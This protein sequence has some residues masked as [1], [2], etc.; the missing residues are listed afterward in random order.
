MGSTNPARL[1]MCVLRARLM[2]PLCLKVMDR[3]ERILVATDFSPGS[4]RAVKY[5]FALAE[6]FGAK[7]ELLHVWLPPQLV[8]QEFVLAD[9]AEPTTIGEY[10]LRAAD[11]R[12]R[13]FLDECGLSPRPP[14][15]IEMGS[16][17][18]IIVEKAKGYDL[19]VMGTHGRK[20]LVRLLMGSV[21]RNVVQHSPC[22]VLTVPLDGLG[23]R[24]QGD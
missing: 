20:G 19:V 8:G 1:V 13:D 24:S 9:T 3:F 23:V 17:P 16:P 4:A 11:R 21:A 22:P 6:A 10:A 2:H 15:R 7:V 18:K 14:Y 12:M 5:A